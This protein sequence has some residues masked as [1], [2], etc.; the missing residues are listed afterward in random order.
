MFRKSLVIGM[1]LLVSGFMLQAC[2]GGG[3]SGTTPMGSAQVS[4]TDA[5]GD[6]DHV[7]I[8]V[9]EVLFHTSDAAGPNDAGWLKYPLTTPVTVDL[10]TLDG[11]VGNAIWGN[12]T[13]PVGNY[14]QIRLLLVGNGATL[15]PSA[16]SAGLTYNNEVV[17]GPTISPLRIP[18]VS[19]GIKLNGAFSITFGG[20]LRLAIDFDAGHDVIDLENGEYVLKPRLAYFDL[21]NAGAIVGQ[22]ELASAPS[23]TAHFVVK[24]ERLNDPVSPDYYV[25][26]RY[27][28]VSIPSTTTTGAF[29]LYPVP[30]A[31]TASYD[32][33]IRGVGYETTII[34]G[35]PVTRGST[36]AHDETI[37]PVISMTTGTDYSASGS[38]VSPTGAW[39]NFYQT[40]DPGVT[41]TTPEYPYEVRYRHFHPLTGTFTNY[42]LSNSQLQFGLYSA[43]SISTASVTPQEGVGKYQA[44]AGA[45]LYDRTALPGAGSPNITSSSPTVTFVSPLTAKSGVV[46]SI[47]G[48]IDMSGI[49]PA[50]YSKFT[51][52]YVFAV[53]GGMIVNSVDVHS[54]MSSGGGPYTI[55]NLAS[56]FPGAF[57]G[58]EAIGWDSGDLTIRAIAFPPGFV[59][60][61]SGS[62]ATGV[63]MNMI[64]F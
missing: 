23:S 51:N 8:T 3:G 48:T 6:F 36:P 7:W 2:S 16:Q 53:R 15:A 22:I 62:N 60:L 28:V 58:V 21:D 45:L 35:V 30:A 40:L 64:A 59:D 19:H 26:R 24:A 55:A 43:S 52:G 11:K 44:S 1:V 14:Q 56:G 37:V 54:T 5:P 41:G 33:L 17:V 39:V 31:A 25:V 46:S 27:T 47:T 34:R 49:L 29:V 50:D 4:L 63:N 13:L 10:L 12:I 18:D 42:E 9:K 20:T 38:I 57:Y 61:S 32:I